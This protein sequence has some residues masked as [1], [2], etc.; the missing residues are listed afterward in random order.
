MDGVSGTRG[1]GGRGGRLHTSSSEVVQ[2]L[3]DVTLPDRKG[4]F[5]LELL[6]S[7]SPQALPAT[8]PPTYGEMYAPENR[9]LQ[10]KNAEALSAVGWS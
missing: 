1:V 4:D 2:A 6:F 10:K 8:W 7:E 9:E 5:W 3:T